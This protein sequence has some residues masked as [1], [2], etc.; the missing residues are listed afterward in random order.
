VSVEIAQ[1]G[2]D[3]I[4]RRCDDRGTADPHRLSG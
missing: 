1:H 4:N 2:P 3:A